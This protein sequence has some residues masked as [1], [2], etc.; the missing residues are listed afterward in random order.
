MSIEEACLVAIFYVKSW[1]KI[2][3]AMPDLW[4][5]TYSQFPLEAKKAS[6]CDLIDVKNALPDA[7]SSQQGG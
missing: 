7:S 4:E 6:S 2:I 5:S 1:N 3:D